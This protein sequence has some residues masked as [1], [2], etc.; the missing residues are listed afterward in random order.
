MSRQCLLRLW[1]IGFAVR[2]TA[3]RLSHNSSDLETV[4]CL[5]ADQEI[6]LEPRN[7]QNPP[8]D[9]LV[10]LQPAQSESL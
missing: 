8:V 2:H 5:L 1:N 3:D 7:V 6:T 10:S 4:S 9:L